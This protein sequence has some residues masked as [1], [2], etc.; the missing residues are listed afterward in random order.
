MKIS[1]CITACNEYKELQ[2]LLEFLVER[3][4]STDE[5]IVQT[6]SESTTP[7]VYDLV[8]SY[9]ELRDNIRHISFPLNNDFAAYK[10][11]LFTAA[12][13]SWCFFIDADEWPNENLVINLHPLIDSARESSVELIW[14]PRINTV[15][16]I[17]EEWMKEWRWSINDNNWINFPDYQARLV[18]NQSNI[19][20]ENKVHEVIKGHKSM[21]ALPA[22]EPWCLYHPKDLQRQIRQNEKYSKM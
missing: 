5:I 11:N 7:E 2:R 20:W 14:V 18:K 15:D 1:Y 21:Y 22:D 12:K 4:N 3:R 16:D 19:R 9:A 17:T 10:N 13:G 6:D 8:G